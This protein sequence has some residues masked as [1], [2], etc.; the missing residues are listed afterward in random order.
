[1]TDIKKTVLFSA[2]SL[3]LLLAVFAAASISDGMGKDNGM[4]SVTVCGKDETDSL[5]ISCGG[6]MIV[7]CDDEDIDDLIAAL[8]SRNIKKVDRIILT[9]ADTSADKTLG[10]FVKTG[11][12]VHKENENDLECR[13]KN[14]DVV[15]R[16]SSVSVKHGKNL[17]VFVRG[18]MPDGS[19]TEYADFIHIRSDEADKV[20]YG[21]KTMRLSGRTAVIQSNGT[22]VRI[23]KDISL[24]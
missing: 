19:V 20:I 6:E 23:L 22:D 5:F 2:V 13:T 11:I 24:L 15:I 16:D 17:I 12:A 8:R 14:A 7:I 21:G 9:R 4:L 3:V 10:Q 1:M 18:D